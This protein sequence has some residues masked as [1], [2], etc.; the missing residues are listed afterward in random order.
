MSRNNQRQG[1]ANGVSYHRTFLYPG[2]KGMK[3]PVGA[4]IRIDYK[5][6]SLISEF[7]ISG[8]HPV[9]SFKKSARPLIR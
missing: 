6:V 5:R 1:N 4:Q 7:L 2:L 9:E 8:I 3:L